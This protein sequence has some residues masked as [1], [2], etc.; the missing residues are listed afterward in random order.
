[1][2][3]QAEIIQDPGRFIEIDPEMAE[4]LLEQRE[5][6]KRLLLITNSDFQY[7]DKMMSFS[8]DRF[9]PDSMKWRDLFD[10]VCR[11]VYHAS[12]LLYH[13]FQL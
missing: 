9:L 10:M 5:A 3:F 11:I 1:M 7:T 4:T 8:Y 2:L 12:S 6:G 13:N